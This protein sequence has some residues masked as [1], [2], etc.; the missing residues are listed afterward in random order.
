MRE[1]LKEDQDS[2]PILA[3][4]VQNNGQAKEATTERT[5]RDRL[6]DT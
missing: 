5:R 4:E 1:T 3:E 2:R 6:R